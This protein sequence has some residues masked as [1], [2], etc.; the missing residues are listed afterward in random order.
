MFRVLE[1]L[2]STNL[3]L[4]KLFLYVVRHFLRFVAN[5]RLCIFFLCA[6]MFLLSM[7]I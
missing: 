3:S 1:Q 6:C 7:H 2:S 4:R 5:V